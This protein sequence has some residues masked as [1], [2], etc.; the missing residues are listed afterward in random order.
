M[1]E[2]EHEEMWDD[3][4]DAILSQASSYLK[5]ITKLPERFPERLKDD[6]W[7]FYNKDTMLGNLSHGDIISLNNRVGL[8]AAVTHL[9]KPDYEYT[10]EGFRDVMN[11]KNFVKNQALRGKDG[12]ERVMETQ[13]TRMS[14]AS[15]ESP[16]TSLI[17]PR[18]QGIVGKAISVMT[19]RR[20]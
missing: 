7:A 16:G 9:T 14:F 8:Q 6:F 15:S 4:Q 2:V 19:G 20:P 17:S 13:Q 11:L 12:F 18:R 1:A 10:E 3:G 5:D